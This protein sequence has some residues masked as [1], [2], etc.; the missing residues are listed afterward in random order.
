[1]NKPGMDKPASWSCLKLP[2]TIVPEAF[3][4]TGN[5]VLKQLAAVLNDSLDNVSKTMD[6]VLQE[7]GWSIANRGF[8]IEE[9]K[10]FAEHRRT[11]CY[12]FYGSRLI[13]AHAREDCKK[14][15]IVGAYWSGMWYFMKGVGNYA[16]A[17]SVQ[18]QSNLALPRATLVKSR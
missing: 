9:I 12:I 1:M 7:P 3:D 18:D 4:V 15:P 6:E 16:K 8:S 14:T 13:Y 11:A 17:C 5:R 10:A 2:H